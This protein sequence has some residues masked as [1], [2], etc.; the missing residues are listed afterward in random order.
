[1]KILIISLL[2]AIVIQA[3]PAMAEQKIFRDGVGI[4]SF[5]VVMPVGRIM[6]IGRENFVGAVKFLHNE[7][8]P[9]GT[10]SKYEYFEYEKGAFRKVRGGEVMLKNPSDAGKGGWFFH[11]GPSELLGPPIKIGNFSLCAAAAGLEHATVFF[12]SKPHKV[13]QQVKMAPTPWKEI[14]E[15]DILNPRIRWFA[16]DEKREWKVVPI[17]KIWD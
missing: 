13:D 16:H 1:M 3:I 11:H 17:D 12:W 4:S 10:Y 2:L 7:E 14:G 9:D 15:A 5:C 8:R 6:L